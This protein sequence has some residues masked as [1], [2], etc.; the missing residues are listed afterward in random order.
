MAYMNSM[1]ID[2]LCTKKLLNLITHS[3]LIWITFDLDVH[4]LRKAVKHKHS[5]T[6]SVPEVLEYRCF[7][8]LL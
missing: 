8:H 7:V 3:R 1:D 5:L 2:V 4:Y 6:H